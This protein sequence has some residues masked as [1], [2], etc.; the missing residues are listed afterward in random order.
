MRRLTGVEVAWAAQ[1]A[2][3]YEAAVD[4]PGNVSP[5]VPFAD[6][7]FED[8]AASAV[9][10]GPAFVAA[11]EVTVGEIV[12]LATASTRRLVASNTNLGIILLL[13]PLAQAAATSSDGES[14]RDAVARVLAG[15]TVGDAQLVY[16]AIRGSAPAGMGK[17][18]RHDVAG[19]VAV[20][21]HEA[22]AAARDRD[23]V[24]REYVTDFE[25]TFTLGVD[26]LIRAWGAGAGF[27]DA[28]L[29]C[30]LSLLAEVPDTLIARKNGVTVAEDVSRAAAAALAAGG[31]A[32]PQ[33][34]RLVEELR[35]RLSDERHA[36]NPGTTAD[37]VAA[38]LFV[39]LT[40]G[41]MV[42]SLPEIT[43]RW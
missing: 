20:T 4:K 34:R 7:R 42:D 2:C 19:E 17:V 16:A 36:L 13:A 12:A 27:R 14:L 5:G 26:A 9:A 22:M 41:G 15:L 25:L 30:F 28:V 31:W 32:R 35:G 21:L 43:A 24:A 11:G 37:L 39:F 38:S 33:G 40:E 8:F 6:A 23:S 18:A 29:T 10:V 1:I 3:L